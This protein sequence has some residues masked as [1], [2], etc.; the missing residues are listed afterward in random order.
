MKKEKMKKRELI[1][2]NFSNFL[3]LLRVILAFVVIS[4]IF[5]KENV[6]LIVVI[7]SIAA[8]TDFFDGMLARKFGWQTEFGRR[9]DVIADR[10]LWV[11]TALAFLVSFGL[12]GK[13]GWLNC[14]QLILIMSREIVSAPFV[15]IAFFSGNLMPRVRFISKATTFIQGFALPALILSIFYPY[16]I[17]IS[18]PL[19]IAAAITGIKAAFY[20][21]HDTK[22]L[23]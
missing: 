2:F 23:R 17:F 16:F 21:I 11:G 15:L 13:I 5:T 7:F 12:E 18:F 4:L 20:Y 3:T 10:F 6:V 14:M 9:A 19:S 1:L 22:T 8:I